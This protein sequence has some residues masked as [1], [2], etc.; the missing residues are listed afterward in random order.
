MIPFKQMR[1]AAAPIVLESPTSNLEE[2]WADCMQH[3]EAQNAYELAALR[4]TIHFALLG[5]TDA[6]VA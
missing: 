6:A 5:D 2:A 4:Y 1:T 3:L